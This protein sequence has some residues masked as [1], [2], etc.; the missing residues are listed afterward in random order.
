MTATALPCIAIAGP[1]AS[2]KTAGAFAVVAAL[3]S[4]LISI[5]GTTVGD[6]Q[7]PSF[8]EEAA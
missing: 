1:T 5:G 2:G 7:S 8:F 6:P 4:V 3:V